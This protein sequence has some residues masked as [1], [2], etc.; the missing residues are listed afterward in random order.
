MYARQRRELRHELISACIAGLLTWLIVY[1]FVVP[2]P[3]A[4]AAGTDA[5]GIGTPVWTAVMN[6]VMGH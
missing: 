2:Q 3:T 4:V 6:P 1:L 5:A